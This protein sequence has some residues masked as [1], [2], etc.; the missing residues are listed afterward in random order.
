MKALGYSLPFIVLVCGVVSMVG[1]IKM[2]KAPAQAERVEKT[3]LVEVACVAACD[4]G[5]HIYVDGEVIPYREISL[6]AQVGGRV[7]KKSLNARAGNYVCAGDMLFEIDPRDYELEV[8]RLQETVKQASASIEE[9]DVENSNVEE[10]I[11]LAEEQLELQRSEYARFE[12]LRKRNAA[13]TSQLEKARRSELDSLNSLQSLKNQVTMI[14]ARRARLLQ[15]KQRAITG[16]DLA[17]LNLE[18]TKISSPLDGVV[19]QDFAEQDD[20]VQPGANLIQLEDRSKVEVRFNLRMDQLRWLW[21]SGPGKTQSTATTM[22]S[23]PAYTYEIPQVPVEVRIEADGNHFIWQARLD[24]YDG[25][26]IDPKTRTIPVIAVV[27]NPAEV[28]LR[29]EENA[30]PLG[31]PP[32]LLRGSYVSVDLVVGRSMPLVSIP[33]SAYRP[34][35]TVWVYRDGVLAV[36]PVKIAYSDDLTAIVLADS[37]ALKPGDQVITSPLPVAEENMKLQVSNQ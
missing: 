36:E 6:S 21:N 19:I 33:A 26:G 34:D 24:R 1:L 9:L 20:F 37:S 8:R 25:A 29:K 30:I 28:R 35:K 17:T 27:E 23:T 2:R 10:L 15:E 22:V 14:R 12:G 31:A 13:S 7:A 4:D 16:L 18:R 11:A 32:T 3:A 5:F